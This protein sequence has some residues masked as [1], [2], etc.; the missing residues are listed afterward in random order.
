M[1]DKPVGAT[2]WLVEEFRNW[3]DLP[4]GDVEAAHLQDEL[5]TIIMTNSRTCRFRAVS[6][7]YQGRREDGGRMFLPEGRRDEVPTGC[8]VFAQGMQ[9]RPRRSCVE[10]VCNIRRW[11]E[12]P[13]GGH[14]AALE[15]RQMLLDDIRSYARKIRR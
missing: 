2:A 10:R 15:E 12:I 11:S 14:F 7:N 4:Q 1:E 3:P 13:R 6:R 9:N 8:A 5:L